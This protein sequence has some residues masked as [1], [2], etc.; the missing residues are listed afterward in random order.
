[1]YLTLIQ[2]MLTRIKKKTRS[3]SEVDNNAAEVSR[4]LVIG[5]DLDSKLAVVAKLQQLCGGVAASDDAKD[6]L[7]PASTPAVSVLNL[8]TKYY[9]APVE[10]HMH[11][12]RDNALVQALAHDLQDYEAVM[13]VVDA[14]QRDSF[15][16]IQRFAKQ[17]VETL[18]YEVCLLVSGTSS[19]TTAK[20]SAETVRQLET[21]CQENAFEYVN[22][23]AKPSTESEDQVINEKQG[24]E[25]VLEALHCNM[26]RSMEMLPTSSQAAVSI[27]TGAPSP[28]E[29][30]RDI[31]AKQEKEKEEP[32]S[33]NQAEEKQSDSEVETEALDIS[34]TDDSRL[35]TLLQALE[36]AGA[37]DDAPSVGDV[38]SNAADIGDDDD[39]D[40]REFNALVSEVRNVR[41]QGQA[42]TDE[43]RRERAAEMAMKL[44]S[45][46]GADESDGNNSD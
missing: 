2:V 5:S 14:S 32:A 19:S 43:Q 36:I 25:R 38:A 33:V 46:L 44:W 12:V 8:Q 41:D 20:S 40:M 17:I 45:F 34:S 37:H 42:L 3:M 30:T 28:E 15:L 29:S 7:K 13:C 9:R 11:Q 24:V 21:W 10:V 23:D 35:Q 6:A 31:A 39:V 1:M 22:L 18:P 16:H 27:T 26:W 4:L